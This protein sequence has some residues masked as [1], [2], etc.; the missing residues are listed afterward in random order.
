MADIDTIIA[1]ASE[2]SAI[3]DPDIIAMIKIDEEQLKLSERGWDAISIS[4]TGLRVAV[5]ELLALNAREGFNHVED[6]GLSGHYMLQFQVISES[7]QFKRYRIAKRQ[8]GD[9][10]LLIFKYTCR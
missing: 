7:Q 5:A 10:M 2:L 3:S 6:A 8:N 9:F 4:E 1:A